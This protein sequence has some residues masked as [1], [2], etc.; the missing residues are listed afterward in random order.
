M[1]H[2]G[3]AAGGDLIAPPRS[4]RPAW[5]CLLFCL[6]QL[7]A[8]TMRGGII[9][10]TPGMSGAGRIAGIVFA[11]TVTAA[12]PWRSAAAI[13]SACSRLALALL[14]LYGVLLED[15]TRRGER[16][17]GRCARQA[18]AHPSRSRPLARVRPSRSPSR[19]LAKARYKCWWKTA[20]IRRAWQLS[21]GRGA[22]SP[23]RP[24]PLKTTILPSRC[25]PLR[26]H[27]I[28][29]PLPLRRYSYASRH[30]HPRAQRTHTDQ[31]RPGHHRLRRSTFG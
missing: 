8:T 10:T 20:T 2:P 27:R 13:A 12:P 16:A 26:A 25:R 15:R 1:R 28:F 17:M 23:L 22:L 11:T 24:I 31:N 3:C 7:A 21:A 18:A 4:R 14:Y 19:C 30:R 9:T 6:D 29:F 5:T